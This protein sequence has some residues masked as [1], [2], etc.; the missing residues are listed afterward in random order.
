MRH[1]QNSSSALADVEHFQDAFLLKGSIAD[2]QDFINDKYFRLEESGDCE[3]KPQLHAAGIMFQGCV[4][5]F[6][7]ATEV[8]DFIKFSLDFFSSHPEN[9]TIQ[10]N[11]FPAG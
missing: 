9:R 6:F 4:E 5:K 7:N 2:C 1:K 8:N 10:K 3:G 11:I